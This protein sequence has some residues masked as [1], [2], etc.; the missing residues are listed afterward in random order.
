MHLLPTTLAPL[1]N[2]CDKNARRANLS[3]TGVKLTLEKPDT[4]GP[5]TAIP[6]YT[7]T[8]TDGRRLIR[9][10]GH[11]EYAAEDYP[12]FPALASA[13]NGASS[14]V[15]PAADWKKAFADIGKIKSHVKPLLRSVACVIGETQTTLAG[16]DLDRIAFY[17]PRNMDGRFPD[18]NLVLPP[19][20]EALA[21]V[22]V[23]PFLLGDLLLTIA[24]M[25]SADNNRV[26]IEL[27]G[28]DLRHLKPLVVR[29]KE[30]LNLIE[31]AC[32]PLTTQH[33]TGKD[34]DQST[35][36]RP[37]LAFEDAED[38][39]NADEV[40]RL[41]NQCRRLS[42]ALAEVTAERDELA[43]A[44]EDANAAEDYAED[45]E[46]ELARVRA[47]LDEMT[48]KQ[49]ATED[50]LCEAG[51][52]IERLKEEL[53]EVHRDEDRADDLENLHDIDDRRISAAWRR[54]EEQNAIIRELQNKMGQAI[55]HE[56]HT[57]TLA[58]IA[59]LLRPMSNV[60]G[61][62]ASRAYQ[63]AANAGK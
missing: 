18:V 33:G 29:T 43:D 52:E 56:D 37:P 61:T 49:S 25:T 46:K 8:A 26:D 47:E 3:T 53:A 11:C 60:P 30:P 48:T 41:M 54:I 22:S 15:V 23:D 44:K 55:D 50:K 7:A 32:M 51:D 16:T 2:V 45:S 17:Q 38:D 19:Q 39:P 20:A 40:T 13:P 4:E 10:T 35:D 36:P 6:K 57:D 62:I 31:C 58:S 12:T 5:Y 59:E 9:L 1:A 14:A 27:H 34:A 28:K 24:K 42:T 63:L 21:V